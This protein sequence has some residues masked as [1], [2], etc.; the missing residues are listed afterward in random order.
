MGWTSDQVARS[1]HGLPRLTPCS[2][3]I[4]LTCCLLLHTREHGPAQNTQ[5]HVLRPWTCHAPPPQYVVAATWFWKP[6]EWQHASC[7]WLHPH[8]F[9]QDSTFL[10]STSQVVAP[11]L[12]RTFCCLIPKP[13]WDA[14]TMLLVDTHL[15]VNLQTI[16][17]PLLF[18]LECAAIDCGKIE[19]LG[20]ILGVYGFQSMQY[21][22]FHLTILRHQ[23]IKMYIV[24][25]TKK[26]GSAIFC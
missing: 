12:H 16:A 9:G 25:S 8:K 10:A 18:S 1:A 13:E 19:A 17:Q 4:N 14:R 3:Y 7:T 2:V 26:I 20:C 15:T 21:G 24:T 22:L 23:S 5:N 11:M 6:S